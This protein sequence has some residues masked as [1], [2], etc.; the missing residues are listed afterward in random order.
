M[1]RAIKT[2]DTEADQHDGPLITMHMNIEYVPVTKPV[3]VECFSDN[4]GIGKLQI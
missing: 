3:H 2:K 4:V 1:S